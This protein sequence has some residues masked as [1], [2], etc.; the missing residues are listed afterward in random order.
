MGGKA[1]NRARQ[2]RAPSVA[3]LSLGASMMNLV[4][5]GEQGPTTR[6]LYASG[7]LSSLFSYELV[8]LALWDSLQPPG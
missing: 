3:H 6:S 1:E 2:A 7:L 5:K 4:V 8:S